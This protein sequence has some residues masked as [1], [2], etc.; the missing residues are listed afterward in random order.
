MKKKKETTNSNKSA[1]DKKNKQLEKTEMTPSV[2]QPEDIEL[3][4]RLIT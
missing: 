3:M 4:E 1:Q 2:E